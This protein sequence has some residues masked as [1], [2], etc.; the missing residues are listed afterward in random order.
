MTY[1]AFMLSSC[2]QIY[3]QFGTIIGTIVGHLLALTQLLDFCLEFI[4]L[5]CLTFMLSLDY[6]NNTIYEFDKTT[7]ILKITGSCLRHFA[8][9]LIDSAIVGK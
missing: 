2:L 9:T 4:D 5:Q 6:V 3:R 1:I 7:N 8:R